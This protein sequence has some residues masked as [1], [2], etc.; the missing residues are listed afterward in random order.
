MQDYAEGVA[1]A[2]SKIFFLASMNALLTVLFESGV[3]DKERFDEAFEEQLD[4]MAH[5][6]AKMIAKDPSEQTFDD[7]IFQIRKF[8]RGMKP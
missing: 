2:G 1:E 8:A 4:A 3:I 5:A 7:I 6:M